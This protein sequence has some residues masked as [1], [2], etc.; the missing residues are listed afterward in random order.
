MTPSLQ[1]TTELQQQTNQE[2]NLT[3]MPML[4]AERE[5]NQRVRTEVST[6]LTMRESIRRYLKA[7]GGKCRNVMPWSSDWQERTFRLPVLLVLMGLP[8]VSL[9]QTPAP[10]TRLKSA[11]QKAV[12]QL[13]SEQ[14]LATSRAASAFTPRAIPSPKSK[15]KLWWDMLDT[16]GHKMMLPIPWMEFDGAWSTNMVSWFKF[17][18][19]NQPPII[20]PDYVRTKPV[21]FIK[22]GR[23][24]K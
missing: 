7:Y 19:T 3:L 9:S 20:V 4:H 5:Q 1:Q 12:I 24:D 14:R 6:L 8:L 11:R 2:I 16:T 15:N 10:A 23:H 17:A 22:V 18:T 13:K 21:V